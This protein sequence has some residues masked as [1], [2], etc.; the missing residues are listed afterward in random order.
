[1]AGITRSI[2][3]PPRAGRR[4]SSCT[5]SI[6]D[7]L[8]GRTTPTRTIK[9]VADGLQVDPTGLRSQF[10]GVRDQAQS[11]NKYGEILGQLGLV[12]GAQ[13]H[14]SRARREAQYPLWKQHYLTGW[15][16]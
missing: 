16:G 2:W 5:A 11:G 15:K 9:R 7:G 1:M 3:V 10:Q 12:E 4:A 8:R 6:L 14:P 13:A